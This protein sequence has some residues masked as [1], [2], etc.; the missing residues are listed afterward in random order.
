MPALAVMIQFPIMPMV[1]NIIHY[2]GHIMCATRA[3]ACTSLS[4][5]MVIHFDLSVQPGSASSANQLPHKL[6]QSVKAVM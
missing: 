6:L 3:M 5:V 2:Y 1:N 4:V